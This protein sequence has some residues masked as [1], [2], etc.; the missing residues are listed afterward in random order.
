MGLGNSL[1][2][3]NI[4]YSNSL[5]MFIFRFIQKCGPSSSRVYCIFAQLRD[6]C[7]NISL[8]FFWIVTI[9]INQFYLT[10]RNSKETERK[11]NLTNSNVL[12]KL[13]IR[14]CN[15]KSAI[16]AFGRYDGCPILSQIVIHESCFWFCILEV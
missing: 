11:L 6:G 7:H 4:S 1:K 3:Y 2:S 5:S 8:D 13:A 15:F 10:A 12:E 9:W 16:G 14:D